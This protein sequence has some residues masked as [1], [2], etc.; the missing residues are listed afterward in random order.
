MS[1]KPL[2]S[3][4]VL[5]CV[6]AGFTVTA[7]RGPLDCKQRVEK[8]VGDRT[9]GFLTSDVRFSQV[10]FSQNGFQLALNGIVDPQARIDLVKG[11]RSAVPGALVTDATGFHQT[12]SGDLVISTRRK[13][14]LLT[15][16]GKVATKDEES[17]IRNLVAGIPGASFEV[18][19]KIVPDTNSLPGDDIGLA[20]MKMFLEGVIEGSVFV[21]E[22]RIILQGNCDSAETAKGIGSA[23]EAIP[24]NWTV[25]NGLGY[26]RTDLAGDKPVLSSLRMLSPDDTFAVVEGRMPTRELTAKIKKTLRDRWSVR[27]LASGLRGTGSV[28]PQSWIHLLPAWL[29]KRFGV[30]GVRAVYIDGN[31]LT[32]G[33]S[34]GTFTGP[35]D[36]RLKLLGQEAGGDLKIK[37]LVWPKNEFPRVSIRKSGSQVYMYGLVKSDSLRGRAI[38]LARSIEPGAEVKSHLVRMV[39]AMSESDLSWMEDVA[40]ILGHLTTAE[41]TASSKTVRI[42]GV[43]PDEESH[44]QA[45]RLSSSLEIE[46]RVIHSKIRRAGAAANEQRPVNP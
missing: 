37:L 29:D 38:S 2:L 19:L 41:I 4:F 11:V 16:S 43:A 42:D 18:D 40:L 17:Q 9:S 20:A 27:V 8:L 12:G 1:V 39:G 14:R 45:A 7:L 33:V 46:G 30:E 35:Q 15:I 32:L 36:R 28:G 26:A 24:G 31:E 5:G 21:C 34:P 22:K 23:W 10:G 6:V 13:G 3:L 44:H 25:E